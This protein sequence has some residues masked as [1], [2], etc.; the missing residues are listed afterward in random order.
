MLKNGIFEPKC[1]SCFTAEFSYFL[2]NFLTTEMSD[3]LGS[4]SN[5]NF[6]P[7][8]WPEGPKI[9]RVTIVAISYPQFQEILISIKNKKVMPVESYVMPKNQKSW[10]PPPLVLNVQI[11]PCFL[12]FLEKKKENTRKNHF[13]FG[14]P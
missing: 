14:F 12:D 3:R 8:G 4:R 2:P 9:R 1:F 11:R 6:W 13:F 7:M 10:L 5:K